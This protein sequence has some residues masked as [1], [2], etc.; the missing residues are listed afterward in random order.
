MKLALLVTT[1]P[2][3]HQ[4]AGTALK[5]AHA[6]LQKGHEI[7]RVFF[8]HDGVHNGSALATPPPDETPLPRAWSELAAD[9]RVD[10]VL[11]VSAAQRRGVLDESEG[12]RHGK[13]GHNLAPGFQLSGL[14]QLIDAAL[15]ADRVVVFGD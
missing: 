14:G 3:T 2:Y 12:R 15:V 11:C 8:Y 10:L 6:A 1:G 4:A 5:F 9:Y 13:T 7:V